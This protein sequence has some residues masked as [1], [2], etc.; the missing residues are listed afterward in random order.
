[1]IVCIETRPLERIAA[2]FRSVIGLL[3]VANLLLLP[4]GA[5]EPERGF[6]KRVHKSA[7]GDSK[8]QVFVPHDYKG[9][10][11]YPLILFLHGAGERGDDGD[12]QVA[13]GIGSAIKFKQNEKTFPF[14][15]VF[16]QC[17]KGK[18]NWK[19][20][21]VDANRAL[22]I[23]D[24]VRNTYRVDDKRIYLTGL[25]M[26]GSGTWSLAAAMPERWG[27]IVPICGAGDLETATKI[28]DIP[29]WCFVGSE[30]KVAQR[31]RE[32][33]DALRKAGGTPRF[34]EYP[35]VHHNSWDCAYV[36][37]ELYTWLLSHPKK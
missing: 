26:G 33:I 37:P 1:M 3:V 19:A 11:D 29:C 10:K 16:P 21:D 28:K 35:Y 22:A 17:Q 2:M 30:D 13:Q 36:T 7:D 12:I 32:M 23:L 18:H 8:Y 24:E 25:S 6:L 14:I 31:S 27:A 15:V 5:A 9:D 20:G 34:S 4:L